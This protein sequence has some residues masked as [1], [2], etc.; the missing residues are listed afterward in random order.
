MAEESAWAPCLRSRRAS[1]MSSTGLN[2]LGGRPSLSD[3]RHLSQKIH[4]LKRLAGAA[5]DASERIFRE[6]DRKAGLLLDQDVE[7]REQRAAA[8]EDDAVVDDVG[9]KLGRS[10]LERGLDRFDHGRDRFR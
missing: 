9:G 10:A 6:R 7:V 8:G 3:N 2:S 1:L 4:V 5:N